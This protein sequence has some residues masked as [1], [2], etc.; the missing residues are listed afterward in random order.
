MANSRIGGLIQFKIEGELFQAKGSFTYDLG[1]P[2][3]E[4][5]SGPRGM[6]PSI[7]TFDVL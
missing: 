1:V 5:V 4:M 3:K 6:P 7:S 2:K